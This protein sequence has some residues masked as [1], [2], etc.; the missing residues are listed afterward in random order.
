MQNKTHQL[1]NHN[2]LKN[3]VTVKMALTEHKT[4]EPGR[5]RT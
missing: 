3:Q 2:I 5:H 4:T 1:D